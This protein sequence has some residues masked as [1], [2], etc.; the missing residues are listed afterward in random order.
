MSQMKVFSFPWVTLSLC[1]LQGLSQSQVFLEHL[2]HFAVHCFEASL[3][4]F[5]GFIRTH[6]ILQTPMIFCLTMLPI[7][8][9]FACVSFP[10]LPPLFLHF[11]GFLHSYPISAPHVYAYVCLSR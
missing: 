8:A 7:P 2:A 3:R 9:P 11:H 6:F 10:R 1:S 4:N 5:P